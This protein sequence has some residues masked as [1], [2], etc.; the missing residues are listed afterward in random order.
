MGGLIF[1]IIVDCF[2]RFVNLNLGEGDSC[3]LFGFLFVE[4]RN[5]VFVRMDVE[6]YLEMVDRVNVE[7][8]E[9]VVIV[10]VE[11][12]LWMDGFVEGMD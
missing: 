3:S 7:E 11:D 5:E 2:I 12:E 10:D 1:V 4:N 9:F 6:E 8:G